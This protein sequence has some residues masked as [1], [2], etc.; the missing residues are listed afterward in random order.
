MNKEERVKGEEKDLIYYKVMSSLGCDGLF[1]NSAFGDA[2]VQYKMGQW[3]SAPECLASHGYH[4]FVF[5]NLEKA[6]DFRRI[7][8]SLIFKCLVKGVAPELPKF[9]QVFGLA[10]GRLDEDKNGMFPSGTKMVKSV[11]LIESINCK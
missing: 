8:E 6:E 9:L 11:K 2:R 3:V 5:D 10:N 7:G 1:S 4:L